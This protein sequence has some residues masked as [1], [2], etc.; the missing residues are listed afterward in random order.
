MQQDLSSQPRNLACNHSWWME[1]MMIAMIMNGYDVDY[2]DYYKSNVMAKKW[3][4]CK[5]N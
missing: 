5:N 3:P 1:M 4:S 2:E